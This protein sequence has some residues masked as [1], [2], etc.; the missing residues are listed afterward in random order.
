MDVNMNERTLRRIHRQRGQTLPVWAFGILTV[1]TLIA[2]AI[3]YGSMVL[4]QIR[5][6]NA[7][8]AAA[9]G[10][11]SVQAT[12]WNETT[13]LLTA[14]AVEEYRIRAIMQATLLTI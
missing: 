14:A 12:Q 10:L 6:Q 13:A 5:A 2:F 1:L 9:Q 3:S 11:L 8:D 4:W 7:A